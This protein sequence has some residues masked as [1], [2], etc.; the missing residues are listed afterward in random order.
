MGVDRRVQGRLRSG[1]H[2]PNRRRPVCGHQWSF[3]QELTR[4]PS[5]AITSRSGKRST[6]ETGTITT[7][8]M[9]APVTQFTR[10]IFFRQHESEAR[11]AFVVGTTDTLEVLESDPSIRIADVQRPPRLQRRDFPPCATKHK[12]P[13]PPATREVLAAVARCLGRRN[14]FPKC[15][16]CHCDGPLKSSVLRQPSE[17]LDSHIDQHTI[18][19]CL[20]S[21][22][23]ADN[24]SALKK[25]LHGIVLRSGYE[26][27][28]SSKPARSARMSE[29]SRYS[30]R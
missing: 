14:K 27:C 5:R 28:S 20:L 30:M 22:I 18:G 10:L 3:R 23:D 4:A 25:I 12:D 11:L 24:L 21:G 17:W 8:F 7:R 9:V 2:L 1:T 26:A 6:S 15:G 29:P 16:R 19:D 13:V